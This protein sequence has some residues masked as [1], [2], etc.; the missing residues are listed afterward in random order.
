[1][2]FADVTAAY[3]VLGDPDKRAEFD[4]FGEETQ[5]FHTRQQWEKKR[6]GGNA[7]DFHSGSRVILQ[8]NNECFQSQV[9]G[10]GDRSCPRGRRP[11][12]V[13]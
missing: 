11:N 10:R 5:G 6:K 8:L 2:Q 9:Q 4:N 3:S 1:M 13:E 7:G 12:R